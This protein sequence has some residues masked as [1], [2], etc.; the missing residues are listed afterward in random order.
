MLSIE[1]VEVENNFGGK[2]IQ[3]GLFLPCT[4]LKL[5][6]CVIIKSKCNKGMKAN[7]QE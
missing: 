4:K 7:K 5:G 6:Q 2:Y 3:I 1:G